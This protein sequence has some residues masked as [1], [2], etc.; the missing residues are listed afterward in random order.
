MHSE[1]SNFTD[2]SSFPNKKMAEAG[3][4]QTSSTQNEK[5]CFAVVKGVISQVKACFFN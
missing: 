1:K 5:G 2:G 4:F 3:V